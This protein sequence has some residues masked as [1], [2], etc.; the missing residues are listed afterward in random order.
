MEW[1]DSAVSSQTGWA[2]WLT[3]LPA[4]GKT[5][6]AYELRQQLMQ[7]HIPVVVLD[8]DDLRVILC[9]VSR[10]DEDAR[11]DFYMRLTQ[12]AE[13][14]VRQE[15]NVII[16]ATAN[17]RAYRQF[18]RTHLPNFTEI[19]VKCPLAVCHSR[20]PKGLYARALAGEI[21]NFPG[22][23]IDYEEPLAPDFIIDSAQ[24]APEEAV[25]SLTTR[26]FVSEVEAHRR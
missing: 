8:S 4:S 23:D 10:Y 5:T 22:V 2:I 7:L 17:R 1:D 19:W 26:L 21:R 12:L 24:L 15:M 18:A 11:V 25:D 13:L 9:A 20:D 16:A 3:G 6:I 14:L